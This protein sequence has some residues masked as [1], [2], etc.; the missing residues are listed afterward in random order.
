MKLNKILAQSL[1]LLGSV[2]MAAA[3]KAGGLEL[4]GRQEP[5]W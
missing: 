5:G 3:A 2:G 1:L 4:L